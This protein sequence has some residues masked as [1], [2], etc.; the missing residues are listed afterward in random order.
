MGGVC[1]VYS[2]REPVIF[3]LLSTTQR[4][5]HL[6]QEWSG[7]AISKNQNITYVVKP[8]IVR[9]A[10]P[11]RKITHED[12]EDRPLDAYQGIMGIGATNA[13]EKQPMCVYSQFGQF[14]L[15]FDGRI[16]NLD[17]LNE[18]ILEKGQTLYRKNETELLTK[19]IAKGDSVVN[20][21]KYMNDVVEGSYSIVV[22]NGDSIYAA[23]DPLA[24]N[25][26]Q[27]G[28]LDGKLVV[29]SETD[30]IRRAGV[31]FKRDLNPGEIIK[32]SEKGIETVGQMESIRRAH[33]SF[34]PVYTSRADAI[35]DGITSDI[36]RKKIGAWH[37]AQDLKEGFRFD[38]T[39]GMQMSGTSYGLGASTASRELFDEYQHFVPY[40][41]AFLY[42]RFSWRSYI[43]P[44]Q[45]ARDRMASEKVSVMEH[46]VKGKIFSLYDDS[47]VRGTVFARTIADLM[48]AGA[49]E[50]H[51]RIGYPP[52]E[53]VCLL[54]SST[55]SKKELAIY[56][57]ND[58]EGIR[59]HIGA[60]TLRYTPLE[61]M[62]GIMTEGT[63]LTKNDFCTF[64][65]NSVNPI[66]G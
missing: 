50:V 12:E 53:D 16:L 56:K 8:Y 46:T 48:A 58:V 65:A 66:R 51:A 14:A 20:G 17:S 57:Y 31:E 59:K 42:D 4:L 6:G 29:A 64:C 19:L 28:E 45:K 3:D 49:K 23:R 55:K 33:C 36:V 37:M 25:P 18:S 5:Q 41:E 40:D 44:T 54:N 11:I 13:S 43:P 9:Q 27:L 34:R 26:L 60:T 61:V 10:F 7:I 32:L 15:A 62:L 2:P 38:F 24:V 47:I 52:L 1:G 22:L 63:N 39:T 35:F 30:A 21:I